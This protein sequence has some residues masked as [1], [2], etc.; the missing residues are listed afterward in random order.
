M[1]AQ[2]TVR[3]SAASLCLVA[4]MACRSTSTSSTIQPAATR[5]AD[6]SAGSIDDSA[7]VHIVEQLSQQLDSLYVIPTLAV[8]LS[9]HIKQ[10][11]RDHAYDRIGSP[12]A[13][14]DTLSHDLASV[15]HD[16]HL[17]VRYF[18]PLGANMGGVDLD[19]T[20][21]NHGYPFVRILDGNVAYL[22]VRSFTANDQAER[23]SDAAMTLVKDCDAIIV[24]LRNNGGGNTPAMVR[25]AGYFFPDSAHLSDLYW[26]DTK[27][28]I[29]V[30][31]QAHPT[32]SL[33]RQPMFI[34]T[35]RR[36]F[37]AAE[38]F[39]YALQRLRRATVVGEPTR[40][41]AHTGKG[42]VNLGYGIRALIPAGEVL[43]PTSKAN[44]ERVGVTPDVTAADSTALGVAH[45]AAIVQL[46]RDAP[47]GARHDRLQ[48]VL[49][50]LQGHARPPA[51]Q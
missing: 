42:L 13:F 44:W 48:R 47:P 19:E 22:D 15:A 39:A 36:T 45:H 7:R 16:L 40:G 50:E 49:G 12:R 2:R 25:L 34:L 14:A 18:P 29:R 46:L 3:N 38:N 35:S 37:S 20:W 30:W 5:A 10:R 32:L 1:H 28:T 11:L 21:L 17:W 24:D 31:S 4:G 33:A 8:S 43:D 6:V 51:M 9:R 27:D 26:R 23:A 41:G